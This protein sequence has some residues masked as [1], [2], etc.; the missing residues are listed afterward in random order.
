MRHQLLFLLLLTLLLTACDR[1]G[2]EAAAGAADEAA[3]MTPDTFALAYY[4]VSDSVSLFLEDFE[5]PQANYKIRSLRVESGSEAF[6]RLVA[7]SLAADILTPDA[8]ILGGD[9]AKAYSEMIARNLADY[10]LRNANEED[11]DRA[12]DMP[13][14]Y[15]ESVEWTARP[16]Y[17]RNGYLTVAHDAYSYMGGAHGIYG[18]T[19]KTFADNPAR[20]LRLTDL[21]AA[22]VD[23]V[24]LLALLLNRIDADRLYNDEDPVPVTDNVGM[25]ADG[26][27]FIYYPYEIGPYA[28]GQIEVDLSYD[29]LLAAGLLGDD[30]P[31]KPKQ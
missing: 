16:V 8:K 2:S 25:T 3:V 27:R 11:M 19:L 6:R 29:E 20:A 14:A 4:T 12:A 17:N 15:Y 7:D 31:L 23:S 13:Q 30:S 5:G 22:P 10:E 26:L 24:A 28:A 21:L 9:H 18:T 1:S